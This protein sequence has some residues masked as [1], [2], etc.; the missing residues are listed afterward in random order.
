MIETSK[1]NSKNCQWSNQKSITFKHR[2]NWNLYT[3]QRKIVENLE[4]QKLS[5]TM[6]GILKPPKQFNPEN[7]KLR[8]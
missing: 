2:K 3:I 1:Q 5:K 7:S 4:I 8:D 6:D